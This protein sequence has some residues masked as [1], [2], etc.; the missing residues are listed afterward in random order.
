M[1]T[2]IEYFTG[3]LRQDEKQIDH[4]ALDRFDKALAQEW[5]GHTLTAG[6]GFWIDDQDDNKLYR[7][8]A[9][10]YVVYAFG[11]PELDTILKYAEFLRQ[12]ADQVAIL[13]VVTLPSGTWATYEHRG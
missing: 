2:K 4:V 1:T 5:G 10:H 6:T 3:L 7:E 9:R 11:N 8:R 12:A 13:V